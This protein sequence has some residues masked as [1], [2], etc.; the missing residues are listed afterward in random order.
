M[1]KNPKSNLISWAD[2]QTGESLIKKGN[3]LISKKINLKL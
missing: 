3:F 1:I 2:P